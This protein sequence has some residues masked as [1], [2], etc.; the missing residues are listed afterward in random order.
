MSGKFWLW[1]ACASLVACTGGGVTP[2][3]GVTC[4]YPADCASGLCLNNQCVTQGTDLAGT[5]IV[6]DLLSG[7]SDMAVAPD[8]TAVADMTVAAADLAGTV[9]MTM[10][11]PD[12]ATTVTDMATTVSDLAVVPQLKLPVFTPAAGYGAHTD[13]TWV[14]VAELTSDNK[15]D[16]AVANVSSNDVSVLAGNGSGV[17]GSPM[18]TISVTAPT[19]MASADFNNDGKADLV[20]S[21]SANGHVHVFLGNGNATFQADQT[22]GPFNTFCNRVTVGLLDSDSRP[23]LLVNCIS[24]G[25]GGS[26]G[27][28]S[29]NML[30]ATANGTFTIPQTSVPIQFGSNSFRGFAVGDFTGD[31]LGDV[32]VGFQTSI[33]QQNATLHPWAAN[34]ML[35]AAIDTGSSSSESVGVGD[36]D[37]DNKLDFIGS[38]GGYL[39][40]SRGNGNGTFKAPVAYP[41]APPIRDIVVNDFNGDGQLD[42]A[43]CGNVVTILSGK[44]DGTFLHSQ[45]ILPRCLS[46]VAGDLNSD[47]KPDLILADGLLVQV[48]LNATP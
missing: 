42:V 12:M 22:Y 23:D 29:L 11:I 27:G 34:N 16:I 44:G 17:L 47:G 46:M 4:L 9:D 19:S 3:P 48:L 33:S 7:P 45:N 25:G 14:A 41:A 36:F 21:S 39:Q 5:P 37:H 24:I 10:T 26:L 13:P 28:G 18:N 6:G 31:T 30:Q 8:L 1:V 43:T 35:Q 15:L 20:L 40:L 32:L 38:S 2:T